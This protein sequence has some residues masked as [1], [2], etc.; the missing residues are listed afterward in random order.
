MRSGGSSLLPAT[1]ALAG[2]LWAGAALADDAAGPQSDDAAIQ[3]ADPSNSDT[4]ASGPDGKAAG[5]AWQLQPIAIPEPPVRILAN[6]GLVEL[7][8]VTIEGASGAWYT[9]GDCESGLCAK[10]VTGP[11]VETPLPKDALPRSHV[12]TGHGRIARA[13]LTGAANRLGDS[14]IGPL[15][16]GTLVLEDRASRRFEVDLGLDAAF[17]DL[18]PRIASVGVPGGGEDAVYVVRSDAQLGAALIAVGLEGEGLPVVEAQTAPVG[19]P[20]G[21]LNPVGF[22]D[23]TG[24]GRTQLA[25][26][27]SPDAG[28]TL[29]ILDVAK[30]DFKLR[31][32]IPGV[33]NHIPGRPIEDLAAIAEF[34]AGNGPAIAV[35][36]AKRTAIRILSFA[37]GKVGE[38]ADI[39]LPATV[40]TEMVGIA[41]SGG[42]HPMLLMGLADG[43]LVLLH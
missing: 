25:I 28:G 17:E 39:A 5:P 24:E 18:R 4:P 33:S 20:G 14:A 37:G 16:A 6:T 12:A 30:H 32:A 3:V 41:G 34:D 1:L 38:P 29:Q 13:W 40:A 9:I 23:F 8:S 42:Q 10:L 19:R 21:W 7:A 43:E 11:H 15:V 2:C 26:V 35:P 31:F 27:V 22:A 36:D